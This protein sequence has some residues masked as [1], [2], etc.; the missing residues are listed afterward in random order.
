M[1]LWKTNLQVPSLS[2]F[3]SSKQLML[4][5]PLSGTRDLRTIVT[6][7]R[8]HTVW[9]VPLQHSKMAPL[10]TMGG[11]TLGRTL[12]SLFPDI[13]FQ[14]GIFIM[15]YV[16]PTKVSREN[17]PELSMNV[18][19]Q[20]SRNSKIREQWSWNPSFIKYLETKF[21]ETLMNSAL[22]RNGTVRNYDWTHVVLYFFN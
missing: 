22:T 17:A 20:S 14:T 3:S 8:R 12:H 13:Y 19:W 16:S 21:C 5:P 2:G 11:H 7:S 4:L 9:S 15:E 1:R 6:S 18:K 10:S